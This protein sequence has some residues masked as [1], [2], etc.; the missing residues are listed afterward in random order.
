MHEE[1]TLARLEALKA[2][3]E[4]IHA[5][6]AIGG[7]CAKSLGGS[8]VCREM[9]AHEHLCEL[10]SRTNQQWL[11]FQAFRRALPQELSPAATRALSLLIRTYRAA[12]PTGGF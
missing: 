5:N 4:R 1:Q 6:Q 9:T 12:Y 8:P 2:E 11:D 7:E 10:E 3:A